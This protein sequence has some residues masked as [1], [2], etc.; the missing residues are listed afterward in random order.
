[1][2]WCVKC[3]KGKKV[4]NMRWLV[5]G[6]KYDLFVFIIFFVLYLYSG[7][8][9]KTRE[10]VFHRCRGMCAAMTHEHATLHTNGRLT[11][12]TQ[13]TGSRSTWQNTLDSRPQSQPV[14][15][16]LPPLH[17]F[18]FSSS[19]SCHPKHI[20][21]LSYAQSALL[22]SLAMSYAASS[23]PQLLSPSHV[24]SLSLS[25]C[26]LFALL[27]LWVSVLRC[28]FSVFFCFFVFWGSIYLYKW[29]KE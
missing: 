1:M 27:L 8:A 4:W 9:H 6:S 16:I 21:E 15:P 26:F 13:A 12:T 3:I 7:R 19:L 17:A 23:L 25:S 10:H 22:S 28:Y 29:C 5:F 2:R 18:S 24:L 11:H 20:Y 14:P